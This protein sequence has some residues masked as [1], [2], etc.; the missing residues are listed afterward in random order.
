[1]AKYKSMIICMDMFQEKFK[2]C[3]ERLEKIGIKSEQ[4]SAVVGKDLNFSYIKDICDP[5]VLYTLENGRNTDNEISTV[6]MIGCYLSHV[7]LW[8]KLV[9]ENLDYMYI[10]ECDAIPITFDKNK[11]SNL[12]QSLPRDW[13]IFFLG[14]SIQQSD[15]E[16]IINADIIK[17]N[18]IYFG[19]HAYV[20]NK[21]GA[22][23][24]LKK[25]F[26]ITSQVDSYISYMITYYD[27]NSYR[28][29]DLFF[30]QETQDKSTTQDNC[31]M[32]YYNRNYYNIYKTI[33][34][35]TFFILILIILFYKFYRKMFYNF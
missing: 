17:M 16:K 19:T 4:F 9:Q 8:E 14:S 12:L 6:G 34:T 24:L 26:P 35:Y 13:D 2:T 22:E 5:K 3:S 7:K 30:I 25:C 28:P 11:I 29:K 27:V 15:K 20:I 32:C 10:F 18:G 23:K 31:V 1:M 21:K 33:I